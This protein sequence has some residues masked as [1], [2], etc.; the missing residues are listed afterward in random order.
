MRARA[1]RSA[2]ASRC[3]KKAARAARG[4]AAAREVARYEMAAALEADAQAEAAELEAQMEEQAAAEQAQARA[5][6]RV[7]ERARFHEALQHQLAD[8]VGVR[9]A[10]LLPLCSCG[11]RCDPLNAAYPLHCANNCPLYRNPKAYAAALQQVLRVAGVA[12]D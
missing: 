1:A 2:A 12:I 9:G 4:D 11:N 5:L 3:A 8:R 10:T 6:E 7:T